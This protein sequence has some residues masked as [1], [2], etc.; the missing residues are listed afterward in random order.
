[1]IFFAIF[2][3]TLLLSICCSLLLIKVLS[4]VISNTVSKIF[5]YEM[6]HVWH[7]YVQIALFIIGTS[8]GVNVR[9]LQI[10]FQ[11]TNKKFSVELLIAEAWESVRGCAVAIIVAML[12]LFFIYLI[13]SYLNQLSSHGTKELTKTNLE[14]N[15]LENDK[16]NEKL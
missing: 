3:I 2:S 1:M 4:P 13:V 15:A 11:E 12:V 10:F 14:N 7:K 8:A 6:Q 9:N 5:N 16:V